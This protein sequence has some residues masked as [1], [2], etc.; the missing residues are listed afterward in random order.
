M[1]KGSDGYRTR[2][3]GAGP[4]LGGLDTAAIRV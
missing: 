1:V 2:D 4:C 3:R